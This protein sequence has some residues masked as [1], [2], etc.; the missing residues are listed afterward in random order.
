MIALVVTGCA[1]ENP[2]SAPSTNTFSEP[3]PYHRYASMA[4]SNTE[5]LS[6]IAAADETLVAVCSECDYPAWV[7]RKPKIG[8]FQTVNMEQVAALKPDAV[9]LVDGQEQI[10]GAIR[11]QTAVQCDPVIFKNGTINDIA[12]NVEELG[13]L[14]GHGSVAHTLA[15]NFRK[16]VGDVKGA[17]AQSQ[18]RPKVFFCVWPEPLVTIG[19]GSYL[20]DAITVCG[21]TNIAAR[22]SSAYPQ[23][24]LERLLVQQPDVII[25]PAEVDTGVLKRPPWTSLN[26][27]KH[28]R[29]YIL[30]PRD[31]DRLSRP[32]L[33]VIEGLYWLAERIH[34]E[35]SQQ[36]SM[37]KNSIRQ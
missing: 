29:V 10:A 15:E 22:L 14:S 21:G 33:R 35:L 5:I 2:T 34:P 9:F 8:S 28:K 13:Y 4:P 19:N 32:S 11:K 31:Q 37:S 3:K 25:M 16:A 7:K 18:T 27:I 12:R 36:L 23:Y 1:A 26:A 6:S 17:V 20:N 30:P 24:N